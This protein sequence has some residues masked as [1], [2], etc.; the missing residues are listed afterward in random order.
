MSLPQCPVLGGQGFWIGNGNELY[1]GL[2]ASTS[3][4][5]AFHFGNNNRAA[6]STAAARTVN[7]PCH[8]HCFWT[9]PGSVPPTT[10]PTEPAPLI[11]PEAVLAPFLVPKST[12]AVPLMSE[13]GAYVSMPIRNRKPPSIHAVAGNLSRKN[14]ATARRPRKMTDT[15][16]RREPKVLS[17]KNP[18]R[19]TL[20]TPASSNIA[21]TNPEV[22]IPA[23]SLSWI[24]FG[25][26]NR[27]A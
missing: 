19:M 9:S 25:P 8:P 4:G 24:Y 23:P 2:S 17:E 26:Q 27:M 3:V 1:F 12:A 18:A 16:M 11:R 5:N 6:S 20:N 13:S 15:G 21:L 22:V 10:A 7:T 14:S